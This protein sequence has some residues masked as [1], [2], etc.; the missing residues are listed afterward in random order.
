MLCCPVLF[1]AHPIDALHR[2]S[3]YR[4]SGPLNALESS[5]RSQLVGRKH[6]AS[7]A[8]FYTGGH[9]CVYCANSL[10]RLRLRVAR[11]F[12]ITVFPRIDRARTIYFSA[13][14]GART[15]RGRGLLHLQDSVLQLK[16]ILSY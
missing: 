11:L 1:Q 4:N 16:Y 5:L 2:T 12:I 7:E 3:I 10:S 9:G 14:I 15:N 13:L 8:V 6:S